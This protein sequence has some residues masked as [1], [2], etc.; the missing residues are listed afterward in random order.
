[1]PSKRLFL[2]IALPES[3]R[4]NLLAPLAARKREGVRPSPPEQL[5]VTLRFLGDVSSEAQ[6]DLE[7]ALSDADSWKPFTLYP[8]GCFLMPARQPKV[9][10]AGLRESPE[11]RALKESVDEALEKAAF[12]REQGRFRP[13]ITLARLKEW[14]PRETALSLP[15]LYAGTEALSFEAESFGL[16]SSDLR[17]EG[18]VHRLEALFRARA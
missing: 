15:E 12:A 7:N 6:K 3:L 8:E 14:L 4:E 9:L 10:C 5:H 11:L 2:A 17:K 1:M 18:A 16:F 13:H